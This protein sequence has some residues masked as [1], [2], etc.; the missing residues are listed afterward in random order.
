MQEYIDV[1]GVIPVYHKG[2][3]A[4]TLEH[5]SYREDEKS[6]V[7]ERAQRNIPANIARQ[8]VREIQSQD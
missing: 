8:F 6:F 2:L 1:R 5:R 4:V 7:T 3:I